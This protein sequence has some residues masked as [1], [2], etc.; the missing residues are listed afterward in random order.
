MTGMVLIPV[1]C[2]QS[3]KIVTVMQN[4]NTDVVVHSW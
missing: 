3:N 4:Y 1:S 2:D